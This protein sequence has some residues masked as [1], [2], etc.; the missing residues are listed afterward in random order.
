[1][2]STRSKSKPK[3]NAISFKRVQDRPPIIIKNP[4]TAFLERQ[5]NKR[6]ACLE[7]EHALLA[8]IPPRYDF[9]MVLKCR[10][11]VRSKYYMSF[12]PYYIKRSMLIERMKDGPAKNLQLYRL[13]HELNTWT[14]TIDK[15]VLKEN[16]A[17]YGVVWP[18]TR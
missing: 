9:L 7:E 17:A 16:Y 15:S 11:K 14:F 2:V 3:S 18:E 5:Y 8:T 6:I 10:M 4:R 13:A 1:M 12:R